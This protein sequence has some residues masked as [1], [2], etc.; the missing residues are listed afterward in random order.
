MTKKRRR[1]FEPTARRRDSDDLSLNRLPK[2]L[3]EGRVRI[4]TSHPARARRDTHAA[5]RDGFREEL[6]EEW[7]TRVREDYAYVKRDLKRIISI[8]TLLFTI[9]LVVWVYVEVIGAGL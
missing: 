3:I 6:H 9:M 4:E 1:R 5:R 8:S 2:Q 7:Q